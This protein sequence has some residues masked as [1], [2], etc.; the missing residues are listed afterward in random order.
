MWTTSA[1]PE[2]RLPGPTPPRPRLR[3]RPSPASPAQPRLP[4]DARY[5]W[6]AE[7]AIVAALTKYK[8]DRALD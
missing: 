7:E 1:A 4:R 3:P 5:G 8:E 6:P 2:P